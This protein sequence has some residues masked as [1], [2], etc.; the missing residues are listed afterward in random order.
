MMK[1]LA[2]SKQ[3]LFWAYAIFEETKLHKIG[4]VYFEEL[5]KGKRLKEWYEAVGN[6]IEQYKI[7]VLITHA[8]NETSYNTKT[9]EIFV[10]MNTILQLS[11]VERKV[12]F[13]Q[14][15]TNGWEKYITKGRK[16]MKKKLDIVN[17]GYELDLKYKPNNFHDGDEQMADAV[18]LG[19]A[20]AYKRLHV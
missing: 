6:L 8:L 12:L 14:A 11:C 5:D 15:K 7:G 9:Q 17:K 10:S 16:T 13:I 20:V 4:K 1:Y 19:E 18:I 3:K 2:I